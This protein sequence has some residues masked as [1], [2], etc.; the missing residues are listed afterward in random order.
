MN[1]ATQKLPQ[2]RPF[3]VNE[4][5][6]AIRCYRGRTIALD[7]EPSRIKYS[8]QLEDIILYINFLNQRNGELRLEV[9]FYW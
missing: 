3:E 1:R 4:I 2:L 6:H 8:K 9:I 5:N 7:I